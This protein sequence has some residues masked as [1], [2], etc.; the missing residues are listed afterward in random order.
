MCLIMLLCLSFF[1]SF[2][3]PCPHFAIELFYQFSISGETQFKVYTDINPNK[4]LKLSSK[5]LEEDKYQKVIKEAYNSYFS[6][7]VI[8][9]YNMVSKD[10]AKYKETH[11]EK[12]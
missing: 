3:P 5:Y 12:T 1:R 8:T 11:Y 9:N 6:F 4:I 2:S 10:P 7:I